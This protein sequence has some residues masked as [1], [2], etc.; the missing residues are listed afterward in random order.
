MQGGKVPWQKAKGPFRTESI[1]PYCFKNK[2]GTAKERER[3]PMYR[4]IPPQGGKKVA[5]L[6]EK[7]ERRKRPRRGE[8]TFERLFTG[9]IEKGYADAVGNFRRRRAAEQTEYR[10]F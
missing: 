4:V 5:V 9:N 1:S 6:E 3:T 2:I 10:K 8:Y 7:R